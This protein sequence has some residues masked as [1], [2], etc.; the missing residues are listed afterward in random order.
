MQGLRR[1][2]IYRRWTFYARLASRALSSVTLDPLEKLAVVVGLIRKP[3]MTLLWTK[4]HN[5]DPVV[6]QSSSLAP[7]E[8][9][10]PSLSIEL[11]DYS[12]TTPPIDSH[13][14]D[15]PAMAHSLFPPA[16]STRWHRN[17]GDASRNSARSLSPTRTSEDSFRPLIQRPSEAHHLHGDAEG[18]VG[19]DG[20]ISFEDTISP[21]SPHDQGGWLGLNMALH[22]RQGYRRAGSDPRSQP[23]DVVESARQGLGIHLRDEDLERGRSHD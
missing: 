23:V 3:Q 4:K 15:T 7:L 13:V 9:R 18:Q 1:T 2:R 22:T 20:R 17:E 6:P 5:W 12:T 10:N 8:N 14:Q 21:A 11:T 16:I 19:G